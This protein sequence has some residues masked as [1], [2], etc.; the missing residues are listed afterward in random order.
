MYSGDLNN[1]HLNT[2]NIWIPYILKFGFQMVWYSN[3]QS[4]CYVVC[5]RPTIWIPNQFIRKQNGVHWSSIQ[6]KYAQWKITKNSPWTSSPPMWWYFRG[7]GNS[8]QG[9]VE[10]R[11]TLITWHFTKITCEKFILNVNTLFQ[12]F[13]SSIEI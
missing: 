5:T 8:A 10:N 2:G 11:P 6:I 1:N 13:S 7:V 12:T 3:G 4:M 9:T